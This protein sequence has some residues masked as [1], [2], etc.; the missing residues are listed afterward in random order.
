MNEG[1]AEVRGNN[2]MTIN[3]RYIPAQQW[4]PFFDGLSRRYL[5]RPVN[6]ELRGWRGDVQM[7]ARRLP[8]IGVTADQTGDHEVIEVMVGDSPESNVNHVVQ[9]PARVEVLQ[10]GNGHDGVVRIECAAGPTVQIDLDT[11]PAT[12]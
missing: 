6:V 9:R 8:L 10:N 12:P 7:I 11:E 4:R 1:A 2:E 3:K 5:G